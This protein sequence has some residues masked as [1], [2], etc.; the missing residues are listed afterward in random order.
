MNQP[1]Q[2]IPD[3]TPITGDAV[4][5]PEQPS[6]AA[7]AP[8]T[9][10]EESAARVVM[11]DPEPEI[12]RCLNCEAPVDLF[13]CGNCGQSLRQ[14][15]V[16]I[17]SLLIDFLGDA[18]TF[19]SK[20][21]RSMQ[22]LFFR[23]G[24]LTLEF[25]R[26]RRVHYIP[27]VRMYLFFSI[28]FFLSINLTRT[29]GPSPD[30]PPPEARVLMVVNGY[31]SLPA[32]L[33]QAS[34]EQA[35]VLIEQQAHGDFNQIRAELGMD[36]VEL[37][38]DPKIVA[39]HHSEPED[40][41][42][43]DRYEDAFDRYE[44]RMD[45]VIA[46]RDGSF[47]LN[48]NIRVYNNDHSDERPWIQWLNKKAGTHAERLKHMDP[49]DFEKTLLETFLKMLPNVMFVL[50]PLFAFFLKVVYIRRDPLYIDHLIAAFHFHAFVFSF[51]SVVMV[52]LTL[53]DSVG[54]NLLGIF[55]AFV[56]IQVYLYLMLKRI[57]NQSH[58]KTMVKFAMLWI[59]YGLTL[60]IAM[61][62]ALLT[63]I[64]MI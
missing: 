56:S 6:V 45:R 30:G 14:V 22:P 15:R 40:G 8:A 62:F 49:D 26:G 54:F 27:P 4:P 43:A 59:I 39:E 53:V 12:P 55:S 51:L 52:T 34:A 2:A 9:P 16:S 7:E 38:A 61:G 24:F 5:K 63:S 57:Y 13:Y 42:Q 19:D 41:D 50:M 17:G 23:P 3:D 48:S 28:L 37:G 31:E 11:P 64:F 29:T 21:F 20:L 10:P 47:E 46:L 35:A 1:E 60:N 18:F 36:P 58:L 25:M 33:R 44:D 32:E